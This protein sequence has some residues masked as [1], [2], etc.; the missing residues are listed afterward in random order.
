MSVTDTVYKLKM[1]FS[2]TLKKLSNN[3]FRNISIS[4]CLLNEGGESVITVM[5]KL[6]CVNAIFISVIFNSFFKLAY[7][8][9]IINKPVIKEREIIIFENKS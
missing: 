8:L 7:F 9:P 4:I 3:S 1:F 2:L 5:S 6:L